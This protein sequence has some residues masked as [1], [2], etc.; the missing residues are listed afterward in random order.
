M[1]KVTPALQRV[2]NQYKIIAVLELQSVPISIARCPCLLQIQCEHSFYSDILRDLCTV[3]ILEKDIRKLLYKI[4]K[5]ECKCS[6]CCLRRFRQ[7]LKE[8]HQLRSFAKQWSSRYKSECIEK[9]KT[10]VIAKRHSF[11]KPLCWSALQ[12]IRTAS[13][14]KQK[15]RL[16]KRECSYSCFRWVYSHL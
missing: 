15:C 16:I 6:R 1:R 5:V 11:T 14:T 3:L 8:S 12:E 13:H 2:P 7:P 9:C 4:T 10:D